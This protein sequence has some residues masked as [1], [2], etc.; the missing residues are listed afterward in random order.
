MGIDQ[1]P[2]FRRAMIPWY[3]SEPVCLVVIVIMLL[4]FWFGAGGISVAGETPRYHSYRWVAFLIAVL[5]SGVIVSI[6]F[7]LIKRYISR[8]TK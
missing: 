6:T 5:S 4:T 3:D 1:N 8:F 2:V 7:R